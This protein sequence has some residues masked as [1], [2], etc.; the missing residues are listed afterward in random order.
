MN[1]CSQKLGQQA[2]GVN[3]ALGRGHVIHK[4]TLR[5]VTDYSRSQAG[6]LVSRVAHNHEAPGGF[7]RK[8]RLGLSN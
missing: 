2:K 6:Q 1:P 4:V 8:I 3:C 7:L 5:H